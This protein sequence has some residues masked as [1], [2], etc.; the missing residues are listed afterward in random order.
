ML[1]NFNRCFVYL[2]LGVT[3]FSI[4]AANIDTLAI[5][6]KYLAGKEN[7]V[8]ISPDNNSVQPSSVMYILNGY[9]DNHLS[10]MKTQP[11]LPELS[12]QYGVVFVMP[13]GRNSWYWNVPSDT[14]LRMED[15]I[16]NDLVPYID[17]NYNTIRL[18]KNR[19][20]TGNSMGGH[21]ALWLSMRHPDVWENAG[22]MSG[23]VDLRPYMDK[24]NL[25]ALFGDKVLDF[26]NYTVATLVEKGSP[27]RLNIIVDCGTDD[28]FFDVNQELHQSMTKHG[29]PHLYMTRPGGHS[30]PYWNTS[31]LYH[32]IFFN[33]NFKK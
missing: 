7:V 22:S 32:L 27:D 13:D 1:K 8:V 26:D 6:T 31:I 3:V 9:S 15:F 20:I 24:W 30:H 14:L 2:L 12:D 11:R 4:K 23:A 33:E 19:A 21:G 10:W 25:R 16:V 18:A 5:D 28:F 29:I 17:N